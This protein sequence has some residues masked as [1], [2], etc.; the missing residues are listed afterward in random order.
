MLLAWIS[1]PRSGSARP[2]R[3]RPFQ[4]RLT[5]RC[6]R[7][8]ARSGL[9]HRVQGCLAIAPKEIATGDRK[10]WR[11]TLKASAGWPEPRLDASSLTIGSANLGISSSGPTHD[12]SSMTTGSRS[13]MGWA[14][15]TCDR[16]LQLHGRATDSLHRLIAVC[17]RPGKGRLRVSECQAWRKTVAAVRWN[18]AIFWFFRSRLNLSRSR[19]G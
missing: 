8:F 11:G 1:R 2:A 18:L 4:Q 19:P 7:S 13:A 3:V 10:P 17:A 6:A 9:A 15:E 12:T 5:D 14:V 16:A